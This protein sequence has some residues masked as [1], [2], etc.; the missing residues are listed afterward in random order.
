MSIRYPD[1]E[2]D[3]PPTEL[4]K[5]IRREDYQWV[6]DGEA[7]LTCRGDKLEEIRAILYDQYKINVVFE[8]DTIYKMLDRIYDIEQRLKKLEEDRGRLPEQLR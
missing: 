5:Y 1:A 3:P 7:M 4:A 6:W 2:P 8:A